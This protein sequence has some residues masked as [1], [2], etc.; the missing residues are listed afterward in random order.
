MEA[1]EKLVKHLPQLQKFVFERSGGG[2]DV[3]PEFIRA[4][5]YELLAPVAVDDLG[6]LLGQIVGAHFAEALEIDKELVGVDQIEI[7]IIKIVK[8]HLA[9]EEETVE[10]SHVLAAQFAVFIVK[11][12]ELVKARSFGQCRK[13][14]RHLCDGGYLR[15]QEGLPCGFECKIVGEE[16]SASLVGKH[17][18]I[19]LEIAE[20][21][22]R[23]GP[24]HLAE[25]GDHWLSHLVLNNLKTS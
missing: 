18:A 13:T 21:I 22:G 23:I 16:D 8:Q 1:L 5:V 20:F 17:E 7:H 15:H 4:G 9:P 6:L 11:N 25:E 2:V 12:E 14:A 19:V 10:V 24:G 3:V